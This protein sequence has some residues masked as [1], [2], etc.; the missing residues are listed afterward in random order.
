MLATHL[1][2]TRTTGTILA[3]L[4][5]VAV[6]TLAAVPAATA[7]SSSLSTTG[8]GKHVKP[9]IVLVHGAWADSS[10]WSSVVR[11]LQHEGYTVDVAPNPLRSLAGDSAY[12]AAFLQTLTGPIVLV[13]HSYGGA[14]V[15]DA[16]TGNPNVKALVYVDAFVPDEGE[17]VVQ[18][19]AER[20]GSALAVADPTTVFS[21]VPYPGA[22][23][24]DFDL[25]VLPQVFRA[26]F[27]NDF[28]AADAA[29]LGATQRPA[30]LSALSAPSG[31]PA[32]KTIPSW[33][34]VGTLDRV[35]PPAEQLAMATRAH[36][37]VVK[38]KAG[39]LSM[40]SQPAAVEHL[41]V[42]AARATD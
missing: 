21:L 31:P 4:A 14:V 28:S 1:S 19:A 29:V 24:G 17:S 7:G 9:T 30:T 22:A 15:S 18:L 37:H 11:R 33:Y 3:T 40:V 20:P 13:G 12:L 34:A 5:L 36:S 32:W 23:P 26:A 16:A 35:L 8:G 42:D 6:T 25:Y 2:R 38:V 10:S 39:H 27:A 41:I